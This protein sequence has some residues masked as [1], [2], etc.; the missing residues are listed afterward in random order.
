MGLTATATICGHTRGQGFG[1]EI[2]ALG[3]GVP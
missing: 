3:G 1:F 2:V